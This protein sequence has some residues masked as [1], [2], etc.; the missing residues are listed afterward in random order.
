MWTR[1]S[2]I[3]RLFPTRFV[4]ALDKNQSHCGMQVG[5]PK[6][7]KSKM[8][9][10]PGGHTELSLMSAVALYHMQNPSR[11]PLRFSPKL[12]VETCMGE[13]WQIGLGDM[14]FSTTLP[15]LQEASQQSV[16]GTIRW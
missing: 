16:K 5:E 13:D 10:H 11:F 2:L 9:Y 3:P 6:R 7:C 12:W 4:S 14:V 15:L 1:T 8:T